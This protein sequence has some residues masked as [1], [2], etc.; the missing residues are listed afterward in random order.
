MVEREGDAL[1]YLRAVYQGKIRAEHSRMGAASI[2]TG[3]ERLKD[4]EAKREKC[5]T[6][7]QL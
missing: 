1:D 3:Y 4:L 2:A 7:I 5:S 6:C